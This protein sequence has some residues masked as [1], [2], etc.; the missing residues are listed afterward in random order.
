MKNIL[1]CIILIVVASV[2]F[3]VAWIGGFEFERGSSAALLSVISLWAFGFTLS[4]KDKI[5]G[6]LIK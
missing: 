3:G 1:F 2:P 4:F 5:T 6:R